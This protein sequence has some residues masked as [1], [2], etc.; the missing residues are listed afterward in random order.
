[1]LPSVFALVLGPGFALFTLVFHSSVVGASRIVLGLLRLVCGGRARL[2]GPPWF[3]ASGC[4]ATCRLLRQLER[5]EAPLDRAHTAVQ[6]IDRSQ[7]RCCLVELLAHNVHRPND[8]A[9]RKV[10]EPAEGVLARVGE[11]RD[12]VLVLGPPRPPRPCHG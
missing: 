4:P 3:G 7:L 8:D 11:S 1:M 9:T 5:V 6:R 2:T 10:D 12:G